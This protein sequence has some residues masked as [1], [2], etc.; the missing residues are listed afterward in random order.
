MSAEEDLLTAALYDPIAPHDAGELA[1]ADGQRIYW[2][3]CGNPKGVPALVLHGGPGAGCSPEH[4]RLFDPDAYRIILLDQRGC[5]RSSPHVA[6]PDTDLE[7]NTTARLMDDLER[8]RRHLAIDRWLVLGGSWGAT[9][10]LAYAQRHPDAVLGMILVSAA[11]GGRAETEW[12]Y[13]GA[14]SFFPERWQAFVET[15]PQPQTVDTIFAAYATLLSDSNEE[16]RTAAARRWNRWERALAT[17]QPTHW[18]TDELDPPAVVALAR[19]CVHYFSHAA[20]LR[21]GELLDGA[22]RMGGI[23]GTVVHGRFDLGVRLEGAWQ[24][25]QRWPG[26]R[27]VVVDTAGHSVGDPGMSEAVVAA[28]DAYRFR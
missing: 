24:L 25:A 16:R 7:T 6:D 15:V 23:R 28:T 18:D 22:A 20:W 10:A 3:S 1:V 12:L 13:H 4:R 19:L 9:L 21:E 14:R 2:E 17:I 26:S 8:L 5:G 11:I 27:L